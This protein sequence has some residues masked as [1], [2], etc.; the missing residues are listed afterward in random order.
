MVE[1]PS[2]PVVNRSEPTTDDSILPLQT[3]SDKAVSLPP[4]PVQQ[5][6]EYI[7][8]GIRQAQRGAIYSSSAQF[9]KVLRLVSQSLDAQSISSNTRKRWRLACVRRRRLIF[10]PAVQVWKRILMQVD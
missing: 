5:G 1:S 2:Y 4:G 7:N 3:E 8:E 9:I 6:R 10:D